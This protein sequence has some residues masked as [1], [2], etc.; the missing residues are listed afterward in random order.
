MKGNCLN[1]TVENIQG[2]RERARAFPSP[3]FCSERLQCTVASVEGFASR[4]LKGRRK[5]M[6]CPKCQSEVKSIESWAISPDLK[7]N[8]PAKPM[9]ACLN[10]TCLYK[11]LKESTE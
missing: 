11:W 1:D 3:T 8:E 9:W 4:Y 7:V 5:S 2:K 10:P 6:N